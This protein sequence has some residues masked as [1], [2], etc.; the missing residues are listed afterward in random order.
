MKTILYRPNTPTTQMEN[1]AG[2]FKENSELSDS[3][4]ILLELQDVPWLIKKAISMFSA[5]M[6]ITQTEKQIV[7]NVTL[8]A[9][10]HKEEIYEIDGLEKPNTPP[11]GPALTR[12]TFWG[13]DGHLC[14]ETKSPKGYSILAVW[15]LDGK[16]GQT[17]VLNI[18]MKDG[19]KK[20]VKL[21]LDPQQ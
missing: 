18:T 5:T 7:I 16:G 8:A 4:D 13:D 11:W 3:K 10:I 21:F 17:R 6:T 19:S 9:G 12:R 1:Y 15:G 20:I 14:V 2:K